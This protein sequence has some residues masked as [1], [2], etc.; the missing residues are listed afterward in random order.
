MPNVMHKNLK[1]TIKQHMK[2]FFL[3]KFS[4]QP[5]KEL[6]FAPL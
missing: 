5:V 3:K 1:N 2:S 4:T 6:Q